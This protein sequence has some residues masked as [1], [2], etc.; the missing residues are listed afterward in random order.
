LR[1]FGYDVSVWGASEEQLRDDARRDPLTGVANRK[2]LREWLSD[3]ISGSR[4]NSRSFAVI[5]LDLDNFKRINDS[6][7]HDIGD[8]LL[9]ET[10]SRLAKLVANDDLVVRLG[11]DEF[12]LLIQTSANPDLGDQAAAK[13]IAA[14]QQPT[15]PQSPRV[16]RS[17]ASR[18]SFARGYVIPVDLTLLADSLS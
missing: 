7:G 1:I 3:A 6:L 17:T 14:G 2:F 8:E 15:F 16:R 18:K 10:S 5:L 9:K 13:V 12:V 4:T 11:G